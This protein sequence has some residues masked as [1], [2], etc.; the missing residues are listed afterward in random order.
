MFIREIN[1]GISVKEE[2][3]V[4]PKGHLYADHYEES[5]D[6]QTLGTC[7]ARLSRSGIISV[8]KD[9]E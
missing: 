1:Y 9:T 6:R 3:I 4:S 8:M 2:D 7:N 5:N